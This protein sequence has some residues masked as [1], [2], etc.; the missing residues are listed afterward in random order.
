MGY[1]TI[2]TCFPSISVLLDQDTEK[3]NVMK[4]PALY[5]ELLMGKE[6]N[7]KIFL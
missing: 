1:S 4:F 2:Y 5:K 6:L 7:L 3:K